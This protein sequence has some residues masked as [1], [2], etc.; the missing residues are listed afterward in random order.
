MKVSYGSWCKACGMVRREKP[1]LRSYLQWYPFFAMN[2]DRWDHIESE[3]FY[4]TFIEDGSF[5]LASPCG[6][7]RMASCKRRAM[8]FGIPCWCRR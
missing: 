2:V 5:I 7:C 6:F 3:Q 1:R 8:H 4:S